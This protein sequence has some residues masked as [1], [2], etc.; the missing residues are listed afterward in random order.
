MK[1]EVF[2]Q[3]SAINSGLISTNMIVR[4]TKINDGDY[5]DYVV[6]HNP[7][8]GFSPEEYAY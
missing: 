7:V 6:Q 4:L 8:A 5:W 3:N 2:D 1:F